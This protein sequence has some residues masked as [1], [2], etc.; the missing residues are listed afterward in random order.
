MNKHHP[1]GVGVGWI[2][3]CMVQW[4]RA[5][6]LADVPINNAVVPSHHGKV[7][8]FITQESLGIVWWRWDRESSALTATSSST[9][10]LIYVC[11]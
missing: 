10:H 11:G 7:E 2:D 6:R 8:H 9:V 4:R 3:Y 5:W 1:F